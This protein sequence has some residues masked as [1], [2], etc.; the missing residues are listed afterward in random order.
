[1]KKIFLLT[2]IFFTALF[3][4]ATFSQEKEL[5]V[6][7][8][9]VDF[10]NIKG[11]LQKDG[12]EK[13]VEKKQEVA[14]VKKIEKIDTSKKLYE[15]PNDADFWDIMIQ[16]WLVKN[17]AILK[18]DFE[19]PDFGVAESFSS[20]LRELGEVGLSYRILY[21]NS[22]NITHF[23]FPL[24]KDKYLFLVSV[25]FIKTMDLSKIQISLMLYEDL[26]RVK[27]GHFEANISQ[28]N[29]KALKNGNFYKGVAP[30]KEIKN[31]LDDIDSLIYTKGYN[32]Q[33]QYEVT[34]YVNTVLVNNKK[35]W[36]NYYLLLQKIDDLVKSNLMYKNYSKIYP[37][38]ELQIN[39]IDPR[40]NN[41]K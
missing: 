18:W 30:T 36:Q 3:P 33:Q 35:Y 6:N 7:S 41:V 24:A 13:V 31:F 4:F 23:A 2:S 29:V 32:F 10:N 21:L 5:P 37:S 22:S 15:L 14:Q 1:M 16:Y 39:W 8:D 26:I 11:V 17:T 34:K 28:A 19:R 25:P 38:P 40:K 12:L 9:F 20:I 27:Q